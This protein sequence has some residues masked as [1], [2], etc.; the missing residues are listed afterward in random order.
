ML[1]AIFADMASLGEATLKPFLQDVVTVPPGKDPVGNIG[2]TSCFSG[3][4]YSPGGVLPL[5]QWLSHYV[6]LAT[7]SAIEPMARLLRPFSGY[8][9]QFSDTTAI[10]G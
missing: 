9:R 5:L 8:C 7:Y 2:Q 10:V 6:W 3:Q 1:S 4:N